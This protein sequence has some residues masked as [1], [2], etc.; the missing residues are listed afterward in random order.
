MTVRFFQAAI[1]S[2]AEICG[3]ARKLIRVRKTRFSKGRD[4]K[5]AFLLR[6]RAL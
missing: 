4:A 1:C 6:F 2:A 3:G 5:R